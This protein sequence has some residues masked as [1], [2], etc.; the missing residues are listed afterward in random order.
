M[1]IVKVKG[2][3][4]CEVRK[5]DNVSEIFKVKLGILHMSTVLRHKFFSGINYEK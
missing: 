2:T 1:F 4:D 3:I 5:A